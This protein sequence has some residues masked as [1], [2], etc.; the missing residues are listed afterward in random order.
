MEFSFEEWLGLKKHADQIGLDFIC[1]IFSQKSLIM[2]RKL[3]LKI[4]KIASGEIFDNNFVNEIAK[5]KDT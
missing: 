5:K 4:W 2:M 3:N 1:S